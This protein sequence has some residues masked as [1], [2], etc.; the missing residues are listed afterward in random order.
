MA[1]DFCRDHHLFAAVEIFGDF[2]GFAKS[3]GKT[4]NISAQTKLRITMN[5]IVLKLL[6]PLG[7]SGIRLWL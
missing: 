5:K 7:S 2:F 4:D 1:Q 3:A 6:L